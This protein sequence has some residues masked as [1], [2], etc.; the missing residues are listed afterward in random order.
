MGHAHHSL[1]LLQQEKGSLQQHILDV[2]EIF[3]ATRAAFPAG[4]RLESKR[5]HSGD[6]FDAPI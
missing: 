6:A 4:Q 2:V 3:D 5:M 1:A